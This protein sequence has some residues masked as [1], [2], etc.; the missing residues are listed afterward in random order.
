MISNSRPLIYSKSILEIDAIMILT[1]R[2]ALWASST[3]GLLSNPPSLE[4]RYQELEILA[5]VDLIC[6]VTPVS[7]RQSVS[8]TQHFLY[9]GGE[10]VSAK[11]A[12]KIANPEPDLLLEGTYDD[13]FALDYFACL[14]RE[15]GTF[16][17]R[18]ST[19]H[20]A[21]SDPSE[22]ARWG[23]P[24]SVWPLGTNWAYVWPRD[25]PVFFPPL[26]NHRDC[27][28]TNLALSMRLEDAL[29]HKRELLF[30]SWFEDDDVRL[31]A[32]KP[33]LSFNSAFLT[34]PMKHDDEVKRELQKRGYGLH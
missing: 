28:Q 19:G 16:P 6:T 10:I 5:C 30:A 21:T 34:V 24:V 12:P 3:L 13:S 18:P 14:E 7:F 26:S 27:H 23:E 1:R 33:Y 31:A 32:S 8:K 25:T 2:S 29:R 9:R 20:V 11:A 22:A 4:V 17:A 15:L